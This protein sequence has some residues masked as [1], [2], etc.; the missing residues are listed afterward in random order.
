MWTVILP[1]I[2]KALT[3]VIS[4]GTDETENNYNHD[5]TKEIIDT[6]RKF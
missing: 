3:T 4:T 2:C 1:F 5:D 6:V